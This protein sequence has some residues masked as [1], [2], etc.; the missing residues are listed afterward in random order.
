MAYSRSECACDA[1]WTPQEVYDLRVENKKLV[2]ALKK[3]QRRA[4]KGCQNYASH[5][6]AYSQARAVGI[7]VAE[8]LSGNTTKGS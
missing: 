4:A 8:A 2:A 1:D 3:V 6:P 5:N 7:I